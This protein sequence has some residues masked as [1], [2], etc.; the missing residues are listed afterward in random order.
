VLTAILYAKAETVLNSPILQRRPILKVLEVSA[1]MTSFVR[2][3]NFVR[4]NLTRTSP[5]GVRIPS[6]LLSS[7]HHLI[8]YW[9]F[10]IMVARRVETKPLRSLL[11]IGG[12]AT[13]L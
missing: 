13:P 10:T 6:S 8:G 11:S 2:F 4:D 1:R 3:I 12:T 5:V 7:I 9:R